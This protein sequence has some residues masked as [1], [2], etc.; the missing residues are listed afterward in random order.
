MFRSSPWCPLS[1]TAHQLRSTARSTTS[2]ARELANSPHVETS[3]IAR[4]LPIRLWCGLI[5]AQC[6]HR[7]DSPG[8]PRRQ[9]DA[10]PGKNCQ[11]ERDDD[12]HQRIAWRD[13]EQE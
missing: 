13:A 12:E 7:I 8:A 2:N 10:E 1:R 9:P 5:D 3:P 6:H 4:L 11:D